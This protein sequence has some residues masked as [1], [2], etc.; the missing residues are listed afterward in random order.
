MK[1]DAS[2][3]SVISYYPFTGLVRDDRDVRDRLLHA[4][5]RVCARADII[6]CSKSIV[7]TRLKGVQ[8]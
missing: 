8:C 6:V 7:K 4:L 5:T 2:V 1:S 3:M